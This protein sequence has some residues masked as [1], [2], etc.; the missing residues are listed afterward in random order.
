MTKAILVWGAPYRVT[1]PDDYRAAF[2]ESG[3]N[4]GNLLIGHG[5]RSILEPAPLLDREELSTPEEADERC[6]QVVIPAANF[7]WKDFDFAYMVNFLE[8]THLPVTMI[9]VGAQ[10]NDRT[11]SSP[12]HPNTLRLMKLVAERSAQIGVRGYYTAEVLAANGIHNVTVIGCPSLYSKRTPT[13]RIERERLDHI[14][15]LAVNLSRRVNRHSFHPD[16]MKSLEN[17]VLALALTKDSTFIAQDELD[18]LE[19]AANGSA[20][21]PQVA[22]YFDEQAPEAVS[23]YFRTKTRYFADIDAW[24]TF[25][26]TQD[27]SIGTRF[28]GNLMALING[29]PALMIIHDSRTM[30]MCTLMG[31]P[32]IH[33]SEVGTEPMSLESLSERLVGASFERFE[34]AF[35]SLYR[36]YVGFLEANGLPHNL[37]KV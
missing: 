35:V 26:R 2:A 21:P 8:K 30:E 19:A 16:R 31:I 10:T 5:V 4:Y 1:N 15:R 34:G 7:L 29:V 23:D 28:H 22:A 6:R 37:M 17:K 13:I 12:I 3:Q 25:I 20:C 18:E 24:S 32:S 36:R 11:T 14:E 27:A 33:V 9:G